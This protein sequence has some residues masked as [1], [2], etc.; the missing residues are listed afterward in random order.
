MEFSLRTFVDFRINRT[1]LNSTQLNWIEV[2]S[3]GSNKKRRVFN[4]I[5]FCTKGYIQRND[6][7]SAHQTDV[8]AMRSNALCF[9]QCFCLA[10]LFQWSDKVTNI[11]LTF[12][13]SQ[14]DCKALV[15]TQSH[16]ECEFL[17]FFSLLLMKY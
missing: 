17:Y 4:E 15:N 9:L 12:V 7:E 2:N 14:Q 3:S 6:D 16:C 8:R 13:V 1:Q 11:T 5:D 10:M